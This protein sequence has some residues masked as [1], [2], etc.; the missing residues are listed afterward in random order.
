MT[1]SR[2]AAFLAA[3]VL[4]LL[5]APLTEA[6]KGGA[7]QASEC[8]RTCV[9]KNL[10][11]PFELKYGKYCGAGYTGC[12][13]EVPCDALDQCCQTHDSCVD[14][15]G[16]LDCGCNKA[17]AKCAADVAAKAPTENGFKDNRTLKA[18]ALSIAKW[19]A[20]STLFTCHH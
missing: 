18:A 1:T 20:L 8:S 17:L 5:A 19:M 7:K 3:A 10:D 2:S 9:V 4:L 15:H 14:V 16:L 6:R 12:D 13:G 11:K